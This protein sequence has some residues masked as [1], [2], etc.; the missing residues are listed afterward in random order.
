MTQWRKFAY[1]NRQITTQASI[2]QDFNKQNIYLQLIDLAIAA[3]NLF[4]PSYSDCQD[5]L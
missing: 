1:V 5:I 3:R 4:Y 2:G